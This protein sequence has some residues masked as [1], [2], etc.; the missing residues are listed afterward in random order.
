M[1]QRNGKIV[2]YALKMEEAEKIGEQI[3]QL[4]KQQTIVA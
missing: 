4:E 1:L 3:D 2:E